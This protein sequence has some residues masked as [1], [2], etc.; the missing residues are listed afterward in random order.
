MGNIRHGRFTSISVS[1]SFKRTLHFS[2]ST[3]GRQY[4]YS[5]N[6]QRHWCHISSRCL[7]AKWPCFHGVCLCLL[8]RAMAEPF[9][10]QRDLA[11][12]SGWVFSPCLEFWDFSPLLPTCSPCCSFAGWLCAPGPVLRQTWLI[13][14]ESCS[15]L[16]SSDSSALPEVGVPPRAESFHGE[17]T[18]LSRKTQIEP[19]I[20]GQHARGARW[21]SWT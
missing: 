15:L 13:E 19:W 21:I 2:D 6:Y 8:W 10:L 7:P 18:V 17:I 20:P 9:L 12:K 1:V 4:R 16:I 14:R 5:G 3:P 11:Q